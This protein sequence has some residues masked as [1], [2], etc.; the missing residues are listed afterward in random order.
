MGGESEGIRVRAAGSPQ[1]C[2]GCA[3]DVDRERDAWVVCRG[4]LARHHEGCWAD[5]CAACGEATTLAPAERP[6]PAP[7][8]LAGLPTLT[9]VLRAT[10]THTEPFDAVAPLL[11]RPGRDAPLALVVENH[12]SAAQ[13]VEV[14]LLPP[15]LQ[16]DGPAAADTPPGGRAAFRLRVVAALLPPAPAAL[17]EAAREVKLPAGA[18]GAARGT[19]VVSGDD[20]ALTVELRV[21]TEPSRRLVLGV[22]LFGGLFFW[23]LGV[24]LAGAAL[25]GVARRLRPPPKGDAVEQ[26][27]A[28]RAAESDL[29][30][31]LL[32]LPVALAAM[33]LVVAILAA[34]P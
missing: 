6:A 26:A 1:R 34:L 17:D 13:R 16:V 10:P 14:R 31:A 23:P 29:R 33:A 20:D 11:A 24:V 5:R 19:F 9:V 7:A 8:D 12:T 2:P 32:A 4:C 18:Q 15:W 28:R 30:A 22:A 21:W 3:L 25:L 27:F